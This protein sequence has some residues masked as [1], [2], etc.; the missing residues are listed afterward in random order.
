MDDQAT[1]LFVRL[2]QQTSSDRL[3]ASYPDEWSTVPNCT[4]AQSQLLPT[5]LFIGALLLVAVLIAPSIRLSRLPLNSGSNQVIGPTAVPSSVPPSTAVQV[6]AAPTQPIATPQPAPLPRSVAEANAL[7]LDDFSQTDSGWDISYS[8]SGGSNGYTDGRYL[9]TATRREP[10]Y[11]M[12]DI[13]RS[14]D[15]NLPEQYEFAVDIT[16]D[17]EETGVAI[18]LHYRG[19]LNRLRDASF[20]LIH[21]SSNSI[22]AVHQESRQQTDLIITNEA[23][24]GTILM[25]NTTHR[26]AIQRQKDEYRVFVDD[27]LMVRITTGQV[28]GGTIGLG[29]DS[30][31]GSG[32][33]SVTFDN[34]VIAPLP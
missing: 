20:D 10:T 23:D 27:Q 26:L 1:V 6:T 31:S 29:L 8:G 18:Y 9:F 16:V 22:T 17:A 11:R 34:L 19:E 24:M 33:T 13:Q 14:A 2:S 7:F 30:S 5:I 28:S 4:A 32:S 3:S 12:W 21:V 15:L 25:I